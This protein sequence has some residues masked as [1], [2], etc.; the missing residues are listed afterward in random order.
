MVLDKFAARTL[1]P[2]DRLSMA[3]DDTQP[4]AARR[5]LARYHPRIS[6]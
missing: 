6:R 1:Q 2:A 5:P 3:A 4:G